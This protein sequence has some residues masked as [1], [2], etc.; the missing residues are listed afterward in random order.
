MSAK[1]KKAY[2]QMR[3]KMIARLDDG[4]IFTKSPLTQM[5]RMLQFASAYGT[6]EEYEVMDPDSPIPG[7]MKTEQRLVL[8]DPSCKIDAF[9]DDLPDYGD[10][11]LVVFASSKQLINLLS[12]R[13][14][15]ANIAHGLITGDQDSQ[16]RQAYMD[17]FQEGRLPIILSTIQAGGTGITLTRARIMIFLQRSWS[18]IDNLQAEARAHRIGSEVHDN[19][20]IIDYVTKD[21]VVGGGLV[22]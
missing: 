18:M 5:G 15:K 19:V 2:E 6:V 7:V 17:A 10:E 16:E 14:E 11:S 4:V 12:A 22:G 8:S 3:D 20:Q 13:L 1:Q 9:M 21:S